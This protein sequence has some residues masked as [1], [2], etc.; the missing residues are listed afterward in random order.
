MAYIGQAIAFA[1]LAAS[2][3]ILEIYDKNAAGLWFMVVFWWV[4]AD[5]IPKDK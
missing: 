1:A 4:V 3:V 5:W 2:A